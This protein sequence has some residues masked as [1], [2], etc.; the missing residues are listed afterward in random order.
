MLS[1][2]TRMTLTTLLA[3]LLLSLLWAVPLAA[4]SLL[5]PWRQADIG[6]VGVPGGA[7]RVAAGT[8]TVTA[9]GE[10]IF[11][12]ADSFH[13]VYQ[14]LRGDGQIVARVVSYQR[15][16]MWTKVGVMVRETTDPGSKF[17]DVLVTPDK[18]AEAQWR[19]ATN[20]DTQTTDQ[21]PSPT[22]FWVKLTRVGDTL[23]GYIS[24]DGQVWQQ[25]GQM[26]VAMTPNVLI[27]LCVTSHKNDTATT[28][29]IDSV[30][31]GK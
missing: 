30:R 19:P 23:T 12:Q 22:P 8:F 27:G 20:G 18:G 14:P 15:K 24:A 16:D 10:D 7:A 2:Q 1:R 28:A 4:G 11:G 17:A 9:S 6:K 13:F 29:K 31:V 26:T 21:T 3:P 5:P 25:R